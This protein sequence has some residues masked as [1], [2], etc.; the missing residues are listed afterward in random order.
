[1]AFRT[2]ASTD[3]GNQLA[4]GTRRRGR[5]RQPVRDDR[6]EGTALE[7][8][9]AHQHLEEDAAE[10]VD[11]GAAIDVLTAIDLFRA[12]VARR[13][14]DVP[15]G[16]VARAHRA[17][18]AEV[19]DDGVARIEQDVRGLDV[20]VDDIAAV[21]V[22]QGVGD[23]ARD[24]ERVA[25]RELAF[26]VEAL[27]QGLALD[28]GHDVIDQAVD[29]VGIVQ[30]QDVGMVQAGGDL[31]LTQKPG[32]ADL[33]GKVGPE[34]LY[35]NGTLILE[36]VGQEDFRHPALTQLPLQPIA[37]GKRCTEAIKEFRHDGPTVLPAA[38]LH[39]RGAHRQTS[40]PRPSTHG[41]FGVLSPRFEPT[42]RAN[43]WLKPGVASSGA[44]SD[45]APHRR[46]R[47]Q[48]AAAGGST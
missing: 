25:D 14:D 29:L 6:R 35:G 22:A 9:L 10:A 7:R 47:T 30:R 2:A 42:V 23:L 31:D 32:G 8:R 27:A 37:G 48:G 33:C 13:A 46:R 1:M 45:G 19:G 36:V 17:R 28:V 43:I 11:V 24:L 38:R 12:H 16:G 39:P 21:G 15:G 44:D 41:I 4:V 18:N 3:L 20:A 26:T 40:L 34:H 5:S